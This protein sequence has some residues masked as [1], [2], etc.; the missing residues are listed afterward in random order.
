[1]GDLCAVG[2]AESLNDIADNEKTGVLRISSAG[3]LRMAFFEDGRLVYVVSDVPEENLAAFFARAG[4]LERAHERLELFHLEKEVTRKK[5]LVSLVVER[6]IR[7]E[8]IVR[9]WLVEYAYEIFSHIFDSRDV[10]WKLTAGVR[11]DHPLPYTVDNRELILEAVRSMRDD[12][13]VHEALGPLTLCTRPVDASADRIQHLPLSFYEGLVAA[14][15]AGPIAL[16]DL[17]AESGVPEADAL[18]AILALRLVEAISPFYEPKKFA[19][20]GRLRLPNLGGDTGF[21]VDFDD[22]KGLELLSRSSSE[23]A[24]AAGSPI[25]LDEL[26][27]ATASSS[28]RGASAPLQITQRPRGS[29]APLVYPP[30]RRRG[31]TSRLRL[32]ASAYIQMGEAEAAAGNFAAAAQCFESALAQK[33]NDLETMLAYAGVHAKRPGGYSAAEQ[34]LE[35]AAEAHPKQAAPHIQLARLYLAA[36]EVDDAEHELLQAKRIEPGNAEVRA[37]LDRI[38]GR[39]GLFSRLGFRGE[40]KIKPPPAAPRTAASVR[41]RSPGAMPPASGDASGLRCKYCGQQVFGEARIC[42]SCGATL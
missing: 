8:V 13:A 17:V 34:L 1:M 9:S 5:T 24:D 36:D 18:R 30:P 2:L 23:D 12:E 4:R 37:M 25:T 42:R 26:E 19:D 28:P 11:A 38:G 35:Q 7:D 16:D 39:G 27:G 10:T 15:V 29:S 20:S 6:D 3:R 40:A 14:R 21:V 31:D 32:L 33:P 41:R 22:A